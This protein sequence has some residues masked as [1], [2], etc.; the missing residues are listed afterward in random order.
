VLV[1]AIV[2]SCPEHRKKASWLAAPLCSSFCQRYAEASSPFTVHKSSMGD[3]TYSAFVGW[4]HQLLRIRSLEIRM[5][6]SEKR[7][8]SN[9][10]A[11][12]A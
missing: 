5:M 4:N 2:I 6:F 11:F 10:E 12:V 9:M 8:V 3:L 7:N 1:A